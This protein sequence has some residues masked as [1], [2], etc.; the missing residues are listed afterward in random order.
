M[1]E[2][3]FQKRVAVWTPSCF[4]KDIANNSVERNH[5]FLEEAL[6]LV[7]ACGC[8]KEEAKK[9][10][11]YVFS[12]DTGQ[13]EQE[14]GGVMVT[15]ASLCNVQGIDMN[16]AADKELQRAWDNIEKIKAKQQ[17]KPDFSVK[18][19]WYSKQ[20]KCGA[21]MRI[22]TPVKL[23]LK[24]WDAK[25]N[26]RLA[27]KKEVILDSFRLHDCKFTKSDST[28]IAEG[29]YKEG[30]LQDRRKLQISS[31]VCSS[32]NKR[33]NVENFTKLEV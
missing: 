32:C 12:R 28:A 22:E 10:V 27:F 21:T 26:F 20:C 18:V 8:E 4:G 9:L 24:Y 15:L 23:T 33:S 3:T 1:S 17:A 25:K 2:E 5:R 11:D 14:V 16:Q 13:R 30:W 19:N 29:K 31:V 7:Q 6:E